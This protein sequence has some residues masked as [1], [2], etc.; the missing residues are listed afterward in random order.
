[1]LTGQ[2]EDFV[3]AFTN[4]DAPTFKDKKLSNVAAGYKSVNVNPLKSKLVRRQVET[5]LERVR[6]ELRKRGVTEGRLAEVLGRGLDAKR[7]ELVTFQGKI[8]DA[9]EVPDFHAQHK[10]LE[11]GLEVFEAKPK[12][13]ESTTNVAVVLHV[14]QQPL[15]IEGWEAKHGAKKIVDVTVEPVKAP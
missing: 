14:P 13:G 11:T 9:V 6:K 15:S 12:S 10:F 1:M 5:S 8:T 2:Q 3:V 7:T 4:P